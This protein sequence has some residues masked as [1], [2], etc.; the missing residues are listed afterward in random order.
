MALTWAAKAPGDVYR[1][2]WTPPLADGDGLASYTASVSGATIDTDSMEDNS[3]VLYVSG[4]SAGTTASFTLSAD[5]NEGET[6]TE[7][8]YLPIVATTAGITVRAVCEFALRKVYGKDETPEASAMSDAIER[9]SDMLRM[10][11]ATGAD[12]GATFPLVEATVLYCQPAFQGA[13][14]N[15]LIVQLADLYDLPVG[16]VVVANAQRGLQ[17][18]KT[19][20]LPDVRSAVYY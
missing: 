17:Q 5:T 10:W 16:P 14:K 13:I 15:N 18:I 4:G 7:T 6:L 8:I 3:V 9:L 1:Y 19:F 12:I 2:T 11:A 20:N